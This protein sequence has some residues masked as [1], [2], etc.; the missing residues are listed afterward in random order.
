MD[1]S[2]TLDLLL[3]LGTIL[4]L[5]QV[6]YLIKLSNDPSIMK[7]YKLTLN[8]AMALLVWLKIGSFI[9]ITKSFGVYI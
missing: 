2:L 1:Y 9:M 3:L 8:V 4:Q 6:E 7:G 5:G